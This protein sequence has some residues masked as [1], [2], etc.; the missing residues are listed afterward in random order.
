MN[1]THNGYLE[2]S[3]IDQVTS[4]FAKRVRCLQVAPGVNQSRQ[5]LWALVLCCKMNCRSKL[6]LIKVCLQSNQSTS[7]NKEDTLG[8]K[9]NEQ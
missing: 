7:Q 5:T 8:Y 2:E 3:I 1:A 9:C 4:S 6:H